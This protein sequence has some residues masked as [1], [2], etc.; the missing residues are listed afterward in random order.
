MKSLLAGFLVTLVLLFMATSCAT[1]STEQSEPIAPGGLRLLSVQFPEF[2]RI[3]QSV[4]YVANI[5]FESDGKVEILRACFYWDARGPSCF[6]IMDVSYGERIIKTDVT[7][8][9]SGYYVMK[10]YV[11]YVKD[12]KTIRSNMVETTI[13]VT[14]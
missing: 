6:G 5:K 7:T 14:S 11:L 9:S 2:S 4:R 12:G 13:D 10:C 1:V 3:R 8:P